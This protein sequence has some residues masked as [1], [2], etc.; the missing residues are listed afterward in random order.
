MSIA[1]LRAAVAMAAA[2]ALGLAC[3]GCTTWSPP[4]VAEPLAEPLSYRAPVAASAPASD[5][6]GLSLAIASSW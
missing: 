6:N 1:R 5:A 2:L 4:K 3:A